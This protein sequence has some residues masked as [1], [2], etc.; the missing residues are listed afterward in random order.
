MI[1]LCYYT[2]LSLLH[3]PFIE[4]D[5]HTQRNAK[6]ALSSLSICTSAAIR[7]INVA[8]KMNFRES[9]LFSWNF[10]VYP[11]FSSSII[12][13]HNAN[14]DDEKLKETAKRY[15]TKSANLFKRLQSVTANAEQI[16]EIFVKILNV[17][18]VDIEEVH[19]DQQG[20]ETV[21][22]STSDND[23]SRKD[24]IDNLSG[25]RFGNLSDVG[26]GQAPRRE[27]R[28]G[29]V[30]SA[31][32]LE[33]ASSPVTNDVSNARPKVVVSVHG[34]NKNGVGSG[35]QQSGKLIVHSVCMNE[36]FI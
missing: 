27:Q 18:D 3:R 19:V 1:A 33:Q 9:M 32:S 11:V 34:A 22:K 4:R 36:L 10:V 15:I 29:S 8:E 26:R 25:G 2:V 30:A 31:S 16:Y 7:C 12:H 21:A 6:S 5:N 14:S 23:R 20:Y 13:I 24:T 35:E 28:A 17:Q